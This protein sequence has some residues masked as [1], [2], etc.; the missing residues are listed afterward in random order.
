MR[1][2]VAGDLRDSDEEELSAFGR[3]VSRGVKER[4]GE[5]SSEI[6]TGV[7]ERKGAVGD[8][9][10]GGM[11]RPQDSLQEQQAS[12]SSK[13]AGENKLGFKNV[14]VEKHSRIRIANAKVS[15]AQLSSLLSGRKFLA[16]NSLNKL[17]AG[18]EDWVTLGVLFYKAPPKTSTGGA[19]FS[20]WKL[21][22]LRTNCPPLTLF[23]FGRSHKE[24]WKTPLHKVVGILNPKAM[25]EK[26]GGKGGSSGEGVTV[27]IDHPDK[28]MELGDSADI[29]KC[30]HRKAN[31][32]P[33][34][35]IVNRAE[36][37]YCE[38]HV[39]AA[40]KVVM[41]SCHTIQ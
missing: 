33:C 40:Y 7:K 4:A 1:S 25:E 13:A 11:V 29:G 38:F 19:D 16:M 8:L 15:Q 2:L 17:P 23:L 30:A 31:G 14:L 20:V 22:D 6:R 41:Q 36:C 28:L 18:Q 10:R 35:K 37:E 5:L 39:K 9:G 21:T 32:D 26:A 12:S 27:S 3:E 34:T 24:H